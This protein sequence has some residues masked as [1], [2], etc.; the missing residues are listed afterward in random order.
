MLRG[1]LRLFL[2]MVR[3]N[4]PWR[5]IAALSRALAG[6]L[7]TAAFGLSS[8]SIWYIADGVGWG[9]A[10]LLSLAAVLATVLALMLAHRLWERVPAGV[11]R[12]RVALFNAATVTTVVLGV[13]TLYGALLVITVL[14]GLALIPSGVLKSQIG[15]PAELSD[16]VRLAVIASMMGTLG[17]GLGSALESDRA[18]RQ[19]AYGYRPNDE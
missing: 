4:R 5:L 6:A 16:F 2:G 9:R 13:A 10:V 11:G 18:V 14:C 1:N 19:A 17:G 15:H 12:G 3:A 8:V 7:G